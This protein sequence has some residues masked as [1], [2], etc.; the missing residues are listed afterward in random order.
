[1]SLPPRQPIGMPPMVPGMMTQGYTFPTM[2]MVSVSPMGLIPPVIRP[3]VSTSS[4]STL[5]QSKPKKIENK[6]NDK[7][8]DKPP[9]TTVFVGNISDRA[10]D[11]MVGLMLQ[12]CGDVLSWKR[13]QGASGKMQAFGFCEYEDPEATLRC[14]R[15]LNDFEIAD[16]KLVVKVDAKTKTLLD[17]YE[18]KKSDEKVAEAKVK[19]DGAKEKEKKEEGEESEQETPET[20]N[21]DGLDDSTKCEDSIIKAG[22]DAILREFADDLAKEPPAEKEKDGK[23][24]HR[25]NKEEKIQADK[26][27]DDMELEEDTKNIINREIKSFRDLHKDEEVNDKENRNRESTSQSSSRRRHD[28]SRARKDKVHKS[29]VFQR[30]RSHSRSSSRTRS[31]SRSESRSRSRRDKSRERSREKSRDRSRERSKDRDRR[32]RGR[33]FEEEEEAL[34]RRKLEKKF[35]EK[36]AAYQERLKNWMIREKKRMRE[37]DKERERESARKAEESKEAR[38]LKEF[39]EDYDDL[40]D[41][42]KFYKG[43]ALA[44][45]LSERE[46]EKQ[47]DA[48]DR[49][50]EKEE[51]EEIRLRLLQE[52]HEDAE[53]EIAKMEQERDE[54]LKPRLHLLPQSPSPVKKP[55]TPPLPSPRKEAKVDCE[56]MEIKRSPPPKMQPTLKP[57]E[58]PSIA[59]NSKSPSSGMDRPLH[60][61]LDSNMEPSISSNAKDEPAKIGF[62]SIKIGSSDSPSENTSFKKKRITVGDVFSQDDDSTD[63]VKKRKL[64]P[65]DYDEEKSEKKTTTAEEKRQLIKKLIEQIPTGKDELF[66]YHLDW[67]TVDQTLMN[68]RIRPW[69][70][71]KIVEYIGE[72]EPTLTDFICQKVIGRS[73]PQ[74]ILNDVAMVLD[75]EAEVFVVKMWRLLIYETEAKK[76]GLVK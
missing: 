49:Q 1:M 6:V 2:G 22:L 51:L 55:R 8:K 28:D 58:I 34:E 26:G 68:K 36:E 4:T 11:A 10:P 44:R 50:K 30:D 72:E 47:L 19:E 60:K 21:G 73:S 17:E 53:A 59:N 75:E 3:I 25:K 39:L 15:L 62:S 48:R 40:R 24:M 61:N 43:S 13:V 74:S 45:R 69:V 70:N 35:R 57:V 23:G 64:V 54:H 31:R 32:G 14:I 63:V 37:Y 71:K 16:K 9:V 27:L 7:K 18:K 42:P 12:K 46:V 66:S 65:L 56:I 20:T 29:K 52:G 41:D 76:A 67:N 38:R 5:T 33:D